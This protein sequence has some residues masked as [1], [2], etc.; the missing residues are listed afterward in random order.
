MF[1]TGPAGTVGHSPMHIGKKFNLQWRPF[2]IAGM[3][4]AISNSSCNANDSKCTCTTTSIQEQSSACIAGSC[5]I[6]EALFTKNA[7]NAACGVPVRDKT[8]VFINV[9]IVLGVISG[10][11][12]ILRVT[13]KVIMKMEFTLDDWCIMITL[14]CGI[15]SSCMNVVGTAGHGEGKDIW[16]LSFDM[17]TRFGYFFYILEVL[18]FAQVALLKL[19]LL[20][21]YLRIF[22]GKPRKLLWATVIFDSLYGIAFVFLAAFQCHPI[23]YFWTGW[24][25]EH[26]GA[27]LN[28]NAIGWANASISIALDVWML[29]IPLLQIRSLKLHWKKK[30]GVAM[31]FFVGTFVTVVSIVR[32]QF[33][34][35]LGSST[36]PTFDQ[37]DVS[38][39]ST[40]EINIGI[41]CTCMPSLRLFLVRLFPVLGGSSHNKSGYQNYGEE[42]GNRSGVLRSRSKT[43][44]ET[45]KPPSQPEHTGIELHKMFV[46]RYGDEDEAS[47]VRVREAERVGKSSRSANSTSEVSL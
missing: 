25:G 35:N 3:C 30:I 46:V 32:L 22:P 42:Y 20:F 23:S 18:Y 37:I 7:T 8:Q 11:V 14:L 38:I 13:S 27:C 17:I 31:M 24:D 6:K 36:N 43:L 2:R 26:K 33:L 39:W 15:P 34:V 41:I 1:P 12:V 16:T 47:L 4:T 10:I 21:F 40:V 45:G 5:T 29:G 19:T 9:T 44:V 28:I